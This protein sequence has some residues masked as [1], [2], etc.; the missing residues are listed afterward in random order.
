MSVWQWGVVLILAAFGSG[1]V[2]GYAIA[3]TFRGKVQ[4]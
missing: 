3:R 4:K 2:F 1:S